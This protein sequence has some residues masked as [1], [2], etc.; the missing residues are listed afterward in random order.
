MVNKKDKIIAKTSFQEKGWLALDNAAKLFPAIMSDDLTLVFRITASLK[1]PV[2]YKV[3]REAVAITSKRFPYFS[4][5]LGSGLFWHYLEFNNQLPR[6]QADEEIPCTAFAVKRK[7]EPLYR[8]IIKGSM[9]SV[10]FIH[11]LTDGTG[12]LEYLKSLLYT[13]LILTGHHIST[14]EGIIL[15][16]IPI[17]EEEF[18]DGYNKFFRKLPPPVKLV[19][20]WHLP[21]RL[22]NKPRLRILRAEVNVREILEVS[23]SHKVSV[24]EYFVSVYHLS[25]QEIYVSGKEKNKRRKRKVLRVEVPVNMRGKFPSRT[26]RN[27]SLFVMPEIDLRLGTYTFE[28]ILRSVHHQFQISSDTKQISRFLSSNVSYERLLIV[29]I[30]P[31]FIKKMAISA[32]Y[33]G[34]AS[35]R[36]SGIVT[37]LGNVT[38]PGEMEDM[39]DTLEIIP[40]PPNPSVKVIAGLISYNDKLRICFSNITKTRELEQRIL[41]HLSDAGIHVKVLNDNQKQTI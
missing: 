9:I 2:K 19:K 17:S 36:L 12:A 24:T 21:F 13:Y 11:I 30:L 41:R 29:R 6:I 8:V 14:S 16:E 35:K 1:E 3:L 37:N 39:I 25:L 26:M 10:E 38:L 33:R 20:A 31:L 27:F 34:L 28:E 7:N 15:P 32:I 18:E 4:V 23:R 5:S 40:P 22:N